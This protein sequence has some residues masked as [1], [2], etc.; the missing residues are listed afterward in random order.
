[1]E[2]LVSNTV[3]YNYNETLA[4]LLTKI[5]QTPWTTTEGLT[6]NLPP[7]SKEEIS[8]QRQNVNT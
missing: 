3:K 7:V 4:I 5:K 8:I 6:F 2:A 1:M